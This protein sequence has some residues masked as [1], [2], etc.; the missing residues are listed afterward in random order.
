MHPLEI[1]QTPSRESAA[2]VVPMLEEL[3]GPR[4]VLDVGCGTGA[5]ADAFDCETLGVDVHDS[6]HVTAENY[7]QQDLSQPFDFGR[8]DLALCLEVAE[9]LPED[10]ASTLVASLVNAAPV[11]AFSAAIPGQIGVGHVNCQWP[12]YWRAQFA[13]HG[14]RQYDTLRARIWD[15]DRVAW[16]YRQNIF[17]YSAE[18]EFAS[19]APDRIVHPA[20]FASTQ[21]MN[22]SLYRRAPSELAGAWARSLYRVTRARL[23]RH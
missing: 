16:W 11:V 3:V 1:I 4:R 2:V 15:D 18:R 20:L 5:W 10:A 12:D 22:A 6:H 17:L 7:V 14:Y 8:F 9:H 21:T 13:D 23:R 19:R